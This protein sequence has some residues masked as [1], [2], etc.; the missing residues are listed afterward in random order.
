MRLIMALSTSMILETYD[1]YH[2]YFFGSG[3]SGFRQVKC[4]WSQDLRLMRSPV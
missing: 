3:V 1:G 2:D 4:G